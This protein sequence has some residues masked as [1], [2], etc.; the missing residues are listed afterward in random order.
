M[1][2]QFRAFEGRDVQHVYE[3]TFAYQGIIKQQID[4]G[5]VLGIW[6]VKRVKSEQMSFFDAMWLLREQFNKM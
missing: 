1:L 5:N 3:D 4:A 6:R 2:Y